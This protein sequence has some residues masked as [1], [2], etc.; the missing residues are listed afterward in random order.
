M[1]HYSD[2]DWLDFVRNVMPAARRA[3]LEEHVQSGCSEC[4]RLQKF[5]EDVCSVARSESAHEV[6]RHVIRGGETLFADW[7]L[8]FVLPYRARRARPIFDSLLE[9]LPVG[10]RSSAK[11]PRRVLHRWG[12]WTIDMRID[13]ERGDRVAL[14]GQVL[15]PGLQDEEAPHIGVLLLSG[16]QRIV[17]SETNRFGEFQLRFHRVPDLMIYFTVSGQRVIA[18]AL[19]DPDI[20]MQ[21]NTASSSAGG[22]KNP[23]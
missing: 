8:R 23:A 22:R 16:D 12:K 13:A 6:P 14:T 18:V 5:W 17:E 9:A 19:P 4:T 20:P 2:E 7:R 3:A 11:A 15:K 21:L 10:V 1:K